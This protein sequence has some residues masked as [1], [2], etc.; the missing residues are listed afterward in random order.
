MR[1]WRHSQTES[2]ARC[3]GGAR[4]SRLVVRRRRGGAGSA[5]AGVQVLENRRV[6]IPRSGGVFW[7]GGLA[8][9]ESERTQ[10]SYIGPSGVAEGEPVIAMAHWPD[11][12]STAPER[13]ALTMAG[14][15]HCGQV[16]LPFIGRPV[17]V[18]PGSA[19]WPCGLY[20][21][22]GRWLYVSGGVGTSDCR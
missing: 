10:P 19:R 20:E 5:A 2:A 13:V 7:L 15:S 9:Y 21:D 16:N 4:Q 3:L 18:S 1:G 11:V 14:H 12:F 22:R 8:D 17:S 6:R